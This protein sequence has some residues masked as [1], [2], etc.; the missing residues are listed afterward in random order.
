MSRDEIAAL[1]RDRGMGHL[2]LARGGEAYGIPLFYAF[3]GTTFYFQSHH[4]IKDDFME[5]TLEACFVVTR[6]ESPDVWDSVQA[7]GAVER[8]VRGTAR[9]EAMD[10]LMKIPFPPAEGFTRGGFPRRTGDDLQVWAL[11]PT[12]W[13][14]RKSRPMPA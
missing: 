13:S 9:F 2:C 11:R 3:D 4:G 6:A 10:Q 1:V 8:V 7:F 5:A 14:G 12:R